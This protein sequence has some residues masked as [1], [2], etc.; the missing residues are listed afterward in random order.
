MTY[1]TT[2]SSPC[3]GEDN[4]SVLDLVSCSFLDNLIGN[5]NPIADIIIYLQ[6]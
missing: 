2:K 3:V 1:Y 4:V 5:D 6:T